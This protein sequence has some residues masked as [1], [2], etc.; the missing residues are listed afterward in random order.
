MSEK[1]EKPTPKKLSDTRKK[2][3]V[4]QSQDVPKLL[5]VAALLEVV[6]SMVNTGIS[7]LEQLVSTPINLLNQP[8]VY[9]V[10]AVTIQCMTIA[11]S[12]IMITL[13]VS[14]LMRLVGAWIQ[15][16]FLLA[17][18]AIKI[19]FNRLNPVSQAKNMF[20]GKRVFELFN[21]IP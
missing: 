10:K 17:P 18:E 5:I 1:T 11:S 8:F 14:V 6:M 12:M 21:S 4:G 7:N 15:F 2:G 19:D 13:E 3:Q 16:G 9:S 20:S